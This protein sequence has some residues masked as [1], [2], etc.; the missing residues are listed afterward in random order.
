[1]PPQ[2]TRSKLLWVSEELDLLI[3]RAKR[4]SGLSESEIYRQGARR[5]AE[6]LISNYERNEASRG[7]HDAGDHE[8]ADIG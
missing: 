1:M 4:D 3:K 7:S 5:L 6:E 2:H 8:G